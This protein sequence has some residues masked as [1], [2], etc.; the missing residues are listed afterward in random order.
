MS[1][2]KGRVRGEKRDASFP[3]RL[4]P[5]SEG[6]SVSRHPRLPQGFS[7]ISSYLYAQ[8]VKESK[9]WLQ[10]IKSGRKK[11][12]KSSLTERDQAAFF[13][14]MIGPRATKGHDRT[15][16]HGREERHDFLEKIEKNRKRSKLARTSLACR[17]HCQR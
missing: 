16:Q 8:V 12:R 1:E 10:E 4:L 2:K 14:D 6:S 7:R 3:Q 17:K 9:A 13:H 5:R 11:D 15:Q